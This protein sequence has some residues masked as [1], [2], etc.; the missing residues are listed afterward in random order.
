MTLVGYIGRSEMLY[1]IGKYGYHSKTIV[2]WSGLLTL[3]LFHFVEKAKRINRAHSDTKCD[4]H[5]V[6]NDNDVEVIASYS[7]ETQDFE[8]PNSDTEV[9]SFGPY[10]DQVC[11][12]MIVFEKSMA[13]VLRNPSVDAYNCSS[14]ILS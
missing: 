5:P 1:L 4:F 11:I 3:A 9:I 8:Q 13:C 6:D 10:V 7:E 2:S 12:V 14:T